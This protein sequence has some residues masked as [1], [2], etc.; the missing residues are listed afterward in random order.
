MIWARN[1]LERVGFLGER[2]WQ[3]CSCGSCGMAG[4]IYVGYE[5]S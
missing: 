4:R 1:N 3:H 2:F 5:L